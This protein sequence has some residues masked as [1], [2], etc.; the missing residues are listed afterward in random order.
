M[1]DKVWESLSELM[2]DVLLDYYIEHL[3]EIEGDLLNT[4]IVEEE[5]DIFGGAENIL[6]LLNV[7]RRIKKN[8]ET[9]KESLTN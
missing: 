8:F 7:F 2:D 6:I 3:D 1:T 9:I 4:T 5:S